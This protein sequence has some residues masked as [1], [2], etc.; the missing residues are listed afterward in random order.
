MY[1]LPRTN[2]ERQMSPL[3]EMVIFSSY[4][5]TGIDQQS[6]GGVFPAVIWG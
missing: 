4:S 1:P 2:F 5:V 6:E 3:I